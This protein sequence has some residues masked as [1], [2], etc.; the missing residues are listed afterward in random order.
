MPF[1]NIFTKKPDKKAKVEAGKVIIDIHEKNSLVLANLIELGAETEIKSLEIGDYIIGS[2]IIERKTMNDFISSMLSKR[3]LEQLNNMAQYEN[4]LLI[5]EGKN[6][7]ETSINPNAIRGMIL[8][9]SLNFKIPVIKTENEKETAEYLFLLAKQQAK[10]KTE[11]NMHARIPKTKQEQKKYIIESFQGI[12]P[13][14]AEKLL[15]K[16]GTI[17]NV[18]NS[19]VEELE[20]EIGKKAEVF[21]ITEENY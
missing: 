5:L 6:R 14:T 18:I 16:F 15:K 9:I 19:S 20:K 2:V 7:N 3:L 12:G 1:Y 8:S 17:K 10:P 4:K 21:K 11:L 13:A